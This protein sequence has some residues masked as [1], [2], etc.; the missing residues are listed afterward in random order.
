MESGGGEAGGALIQDP[1]GNYFFALEIDGVEVAHFQEFSGIKSTA[2]VF[3]IHEGGR[4][5]ATLKRP[6]ASK[7]DNLVLRYATHAS[8]GLLEWRDE[9]LQDRFLTR[10]GSVSIR[11]N[12]GEEV[13]RYSFTGAWPVSWEGPSLSSGSSDL[14]VETLELAIETLQVHEPSR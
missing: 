10:S 6:G 12:R 13:R 7:F 8:M 2:D 14:A 4:N 5:G 9:W 11:D 3:E 1:Y